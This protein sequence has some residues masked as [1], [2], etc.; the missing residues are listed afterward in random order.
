MKKTAILT[1]TLFTTMVCRSQET[2]ET[3]NE[4]AK[5]MPE[6]FWGTLT[7]LYIIL[8]LLL[9]VTIACY[10]PWRNAI[11]QKQMIVAIP[12]GLMAAS[13][14]ELQLFS[15]LG[16][17]NLIWW[18]DLDKVGFLSALLRL[19]PFALALFLQIHSFFA[20]QNFIFG[21]DLMNMPNASIS[22]KPKMKML[23]WIFA[24][25]VLAGVADK[26]GF[27]GYGLNLFIGIAFCAVLFLVFGWR[28]FQLFGKSWGSAV[29]L[30]AIVY[31]IAL[32]MGAYAFL[33]ALAKVVWQMIIWAV[34]G[35]T[36]LWFRVHVWNH[37]CPKKNF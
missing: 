12:A 33:I 17:D 6:G 22:L 37:C 20:Y 26:L 27:K 30:F 13:L 31:V 18:C 15:K 2:V 14:M 16:S 3:V 11:L 36:V 29:T 4:L 28:N 34:I 19:F 32:L 9:A 35:A 5:P 1:L 10:I 25:I 8:L 23:W 7:P 21:P 24:V